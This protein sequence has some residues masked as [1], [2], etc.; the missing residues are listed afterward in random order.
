[1]ESDAKFNEKSV[2]PSKQF[3]KKYSTDAGRQR[4]FSEQNRKND[5]LSIKVSL[6][7][8]SNAITSSRLGREEVVPIND[9]KMRSSSRGRIT[10]LTRATDDLE[11]DN[12]ETRNKMPLMQIKFRGKEV[13]KHSSWHRAESYPA[14]R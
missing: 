11:A 1:L 9:D 14:G 4:H 13:L 10:R 6:E 5:W 2:V 3:M 12:N 8:D 7:Y